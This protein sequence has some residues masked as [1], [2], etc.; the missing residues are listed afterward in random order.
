MR[1]EDAVKVLIK[2]QPLDAWRHWLK[3]EMKPPH[4][5]FVQNEQGK[6]AMEAFLELVEKVEA[7]P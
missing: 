7:L 4:G 1:K 6:Y 2:G 5:A 3:D